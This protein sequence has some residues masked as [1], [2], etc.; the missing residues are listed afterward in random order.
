MQSFT[1][2]R[3]WVGKEEL[4]EG[5]QCWAPLLLPPV[6]GQPSNCRGLMGHVV[7]RFVDEA[8]SVVVFMFLV[9]LR[10]WVGSG[11]ALHVAEK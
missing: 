8:P 4:K 9:I 3:I 5:V 1:T 6:D 10:R 11:A 7:M 2:V